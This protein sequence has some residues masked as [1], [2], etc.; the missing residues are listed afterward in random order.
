MKNLNILGS[1]KIANK[2]ILYPEKKCIDCLLFEDELCWCRWYKEKI[3]DWEYNPDCKV[4]SIVVEEY[5]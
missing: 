4:I 5:I 1:Y 2:E 3:K